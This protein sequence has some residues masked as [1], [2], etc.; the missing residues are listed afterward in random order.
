[1]GVAILFLFQDHLSVDH[2][3]HFSLVNHESHQHLLQE[4][5]ELQ[6]EPTSDL[7]S[8]KKRS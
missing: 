1:M 4:K 5:L 8:A 7:F 6:L 2:Q 3:E